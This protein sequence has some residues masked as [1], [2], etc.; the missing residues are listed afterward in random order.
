MKCAVIFISSGSVYTKT[1]ILIKKKKELSK[2]SFGLLISTFTDDSDSLLFYLFCSFYQNMCH[3]VS[4]YTCYTADWI[5]P[6]CAE[7]AHADFI[8]LLGRSGLALIMMDHLL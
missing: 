6:G 7:Q 5:G 4:R 8:V 1:Y 3:A 2:A